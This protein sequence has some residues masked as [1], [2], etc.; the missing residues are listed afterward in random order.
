[1][2]TADNSILE[3]LEKSKG[4]KAALFTTFNFEIAFFEQFILRALMKNNIRRSC[5][6]V[7]ADQLRDS[8]QDAASNL[9]GKEYFVA[10]V[11]LN[12]AFHPKVILL[13]GD[14]RAKAIISSANVKTSGYLMNNEVF[15]VVEYDET[16]TECG[17][18]IEKVVSFFKELYGLS[19]IQDKELLNYLNSFSV[20]GNDHNDDVQFIDNL[21]DPI[22]DQ[23]SE[24]VDEKIEQINIAVPFYDQELTALKDIR[25]SFDC[26]N[27]RLYLQNERT[28]FPVDYNQSHM[29]IPE[30]DLYQFR[31]VKTN[32]NHSFY[33][34]K[35]IELLSANHS[36]I[37]YG[38]PNCTS[39]ALEKTYQNSGNVE[40]AL[41]IR[42]AA[43]SNKD[44][45]D[46]FEVDRS[47]PLK[48][49][50][51]GND[52]PASQNFVFQYG[53]LDDDTIELHI[54]S[55]SFSPDIA[56]YYNTVKLDHHYDGKEIVVLLPVNFL[57]FENCLFDITARANEVEEDI[58]CWFI[59]QRAI[60]RFRNYEAINPFEE[61]YESIGDSKKRTEYLEKLFNALYANGIE[62]EYG[63]RLSQLRAKAAEDEGEGEEMDPEGFI[64]EDISDQYINRDPLFVSAYSHSLPIAK[65]F[66][67]AYMKEKQP[68]QRTI[69]KRIIDEYEGRHSAEEVKP[70]M[71]TPAEKRFART[72]KRHINRNL[73][74]A[75]VDALPYDYYKNLLGVI[76]E[77]IQKEVYD[78]KVQD[79][80]EIEYVIDTKLKYIK[81]LLDKF[82]QTEMKKEERD[83]LIRYAL[84]I[85]CECIY[86][87]HNVESD[88]RKLLA[89]I[90]YYFHIRDSFNRYYEETSFADVNIPEEL[91]YELWKDIEDLFG[92]KTFKQVK[93]YFKH[94][95]F[96]SVNIVEG[97]T[98]YLIEIELFGNK[99]PTDLGCKH[100]DV[101][102]KHLDGYNKHPKQILFKYIENKTKIIT[103]IVKAVGVHV[104]SVVREQMSNGK[105]VSFK[106][107]RRDGS[108][109]PQYL[110]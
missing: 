84:Q 109:K 81:I 87:R 95:Y 13:L 10:P 30:K 56:F 18:I 106:C 88:A 1:M 69:N 9:F 110:K 105:I 75:D 40:C 98:T 92:Y 24:Y 6:F 5:I 23:M 76:F 58:R 78:E 46:N 79:F 26:N 74:C 35:V 31:R 93:E 16:Y 53:F 59:D 89:R 83:L 50:A 42:S 22:I 71:A 54:R 85:I 61:E 7:D 108:W 91:K 4:F 28:T 43:E 55:H 34:G 44:F 2:P 19:P 49:G 96:N 72:I 77:I 67:E 80:L 103:F 25:E 36:Y 104:N 11:P 107:I 3:I 45:F 32:N 20:I 8:I 68:D 12:G 14:N 66:Y 27:I 33:H 97:Q 47:Q 94:A 86:H 82:R 62:L 63:K 39:A 65:K 51:F 15:N 73:L 64:I 60:N 101:L 90:D 57:I 48:K 102:L 17:H 29:I 38:S 41:L 52:Y 99:A 70:R 37:L 100:L 21:N